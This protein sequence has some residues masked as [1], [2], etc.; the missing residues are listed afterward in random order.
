MKNYDDEVPFSKNVNQSNC[1]GRIFSASM[2]VRGVFLVRQALHGTYLCCVNAC[3]GHIF[4]A[5]VTA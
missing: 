5:S 3:V 1:M 2:P 4:D